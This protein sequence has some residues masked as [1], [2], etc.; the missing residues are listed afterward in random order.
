M[1]S[2]L[3]S[4]GL[5]VSVSIDNTHENWAYTTEACELPWINLDEL[6]GSCGEVAVPYGVYAFPKSYLLDSK[7]RI[8]HKDLSTDQL[9]EFKVR[10]HGN[11]AEL[12]AH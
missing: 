1:E 9:E 12:E 3:S 11:V 2:V 8:V 5:I 10:E 4:Y 6:N 7:G